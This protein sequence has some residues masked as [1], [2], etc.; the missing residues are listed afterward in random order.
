[1]KTTIFILLIFSLCLTVGC[2]GS[3]VC[4]ELDPVTRSQIRMQEI[5]VTFPG[6]MEVPPLV[7]TSA[8]SDDAVELV[9]FGLSLS[10]EGKHTE[11]A[12]LFLDLAEEK[13]SRYNRFE[14]SCLSV[15]ALEFLK[16]GQVPAFRAVMARLNRQLDPRSAL[17][18]GALIEYLQGLESISRGNV[19]RGELPHALRQLAD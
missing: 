15:A 2:G 10:A 8:H 14:V 11:S 1:M 6:E 13:E 18:P 12:R 4:T 3:F 16:A 5:A 17:A 19:S 9:N 7:A